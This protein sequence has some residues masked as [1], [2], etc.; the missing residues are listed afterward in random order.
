MNPAPFS[1]VMAVIEG[2]EAG[3]GMN[4]GGDMPEDMNRFS[5]MLY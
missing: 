3:E 2:V 4:H 5:C 1:I